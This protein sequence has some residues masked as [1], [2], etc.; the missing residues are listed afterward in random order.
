MNKDKPWQQKYNYDKTHYKQ[1]MSQVPELSEENIV[2]HDITVTDN[3]NKILDIKEYNNLTEITNAN[4]VLNEQFNYYNQINNNQNGITDKD[5]MEKMNQEKL[6]IIEILIKQRE[7]IEKLKEAS[8]I[9]N[10]NYEKDELNT[11]RQVV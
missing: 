11:P 2:S 9:K 10:I 7:S 8:K 3:L 1:E 4:L 5:V 6:E